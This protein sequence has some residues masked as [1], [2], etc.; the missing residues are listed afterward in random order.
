MKK[1]NY[2]INERI[3]HHRSSTQIWINIF[4]EQCISLGHMNRRMRMLM[5]TK[6]SHIISWVFFLNEHSA[7]LW[8]SRYLASIPICLMCHWQQCRYRP[9]ASNSNRVAKELE[10]METKHQ[11]QPVATA[12]CLNAHTYRHITHMAVSFVPWLNDIRALVK[13][14]KK[15]ET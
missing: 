12:I 10:M 14:K 5:T 11:S 15:D 7:L 1:V 4:C 3:A 8:H 2:E 9:C 6:R 13:R